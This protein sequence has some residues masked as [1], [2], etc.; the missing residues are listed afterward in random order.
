MF[1][2][3]NVLHKNNG[4]A[5]FHKNYVSKINVIREEK[6][7]KTEAERSKY[8]AEQIIK[9]LKKKETKNEKDLSIIIQ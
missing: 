7:L 5:E 3:N 8:A 4:A 1:K 9:D 6:R 2:S